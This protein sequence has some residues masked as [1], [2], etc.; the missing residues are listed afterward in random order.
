MGLGFDSSLDTLSPMQGA[1]MVSLMCVY[2][3]L[4]VCVI[5]ILSKARVDNVFKKR[6]LS[7]LL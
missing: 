7:Y 6:F 2:E 3:C 1:F 4:R 5:Y